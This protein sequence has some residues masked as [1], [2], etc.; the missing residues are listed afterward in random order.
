MPTSLVRRVHLFALIAMLSGPAGLDAQIPN[1]KIPATRKSDHADNYHGTVVPDPY[2]WLEDADSKETAAWVIGENAVTSS[3]L[4][5]LPGREAI[6]SRL[7]ALWNFERFSAPFKEGGR[8]FFFRNDG[9]QNQ[10]VLYTQATLA[11]EPRILLDPNGLSPD[12]TVALTLAQPSRDGHL[13]AYG[14]SASGSDWMEIHLRNV[15]DGKDL[16]DRLRWAKFSGAA[17]TRDGKGFFYT[18]Y[19][20]PKPGEELTQATKDQRIAYHRVGASQSDDRLIFSQPDQPEVYYALGVTDDG[21]YLTISVNQ[22]TD[23]RNRLYYLDL[24]TEPEPRLTGTVVRLVDRT[25]AMYRVVDNDGPVFYVHTDFSAPRG[26]VVA[27]D[28]EHANSPP[29]E[30]IPESA[31]A[32]EGVS[33][34]HHAFVVQYL[35]DVQ[36]RLRLFAKNGSS[37][38]EIALPGVGSA[39]GVSGKPG[40]TEM[41]YSFTSYLYP[42]TVYR[43]DFASKQATEFRS[44]KVGFDRN[45]YE[46]TQVF[47]PSKD[48]TSI[49][50]FITGRKGIVLDGS[51]ALLLYAYGGFNVNLTPAFSPAII[52]WL[53]MGGVYAV[54]NLRGGAEYGE[55]WHQAGMFERKQNVFDDF[56]AAADWLVAKG[57][58]SH[59]KLAVQGASNGG[60]LIGAVMTQRPDLAQV[61]F[62]EVGVMDMLR[63]HKFTVGWGWTPEYGSADEATQ[64]KYLIKYSPLHNLKPGTNYPATLVTTADHDDRVVPAHS[65]KFAAALQAA[66]TGTRPALIRIETKAGHGGGKPVTKQ[67]EETTDLWAFAAYHLGMNRLSP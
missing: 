10:S 66:T 64:F 58:T 37:I 15:S 21:R 52:G 57:Y 59:E 28:T 31:D 25:E 8:Y 56:I 9:L 11:S 39:G 7:T 42:T 4:A 61:A 36:A 1:P 22:G 45:R 12:G 20:E 18:R 38:G 16:T 35:H 5:Q 49:P 53:E 3:Y 2:R 26:R 27:L 62:P 51:H 14:T 34:V 30:I 32:I 46:T 17:W 60:L 54:P 48:G 67:I 41:F 13:L 29:R 40:D 33:V 65:F 43:Y 19:P 47:Y 6:R 50:M 63:Y 44:P 24:G 55:A 23:P